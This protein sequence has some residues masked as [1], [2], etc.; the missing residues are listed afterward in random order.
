[1]NAPVVLSWQRAKPSGHVHAIRQEKHYGSVTWC[2]IYMDALTPTYPPN[3]RTC[4]KCEA[5]VG[6]TG[7]DQ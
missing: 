2:G 5:K 7:A 1:M 4:P 6:P 3:C